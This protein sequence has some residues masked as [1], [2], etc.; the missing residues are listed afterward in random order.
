MPAN[1]T[2]LPHFS[3]SAAMSAIIRLASVRRKLAKLKPEHP[4]FDIGP[5]GI[6]LLKHFIAAAEAVKAGRACR[7]PSPPPQ[8]ESEW[9][10]A[11]AAVM[12][13][14]D[15]IAARLAAERHP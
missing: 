9:S 12:R 10:P 5:A 14:V 1:L 3:V 11:K 4:Y 6:A 15:R 2:T 8:P 7:L 13:E